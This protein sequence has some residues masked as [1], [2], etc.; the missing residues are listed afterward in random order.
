[1]RSFDWHLPTRIVFGRGRTAELETRLD[2]AHRRILVVTDKTIAGGTEILGKILKILGERETAVFDDVEENPTFENVESGSRFARVFN[3]DLVLG[4]GGG[5]AMDAA[6][7]IALKARNRGPLSRFLR[8]EPLEEDPLPGAGI[9]TTSGTGSEVTPYAVFTDFENQTKSAISHPK[10]FPEVAIIDPELTYSMPSAVVLNTGLDVLAHAAEAYLSTL[11]F[12]VNDT[13]ALH[14]LETA[15]TRLPGAVRKNTDDMDQMAFAATMAGI[16][17]TNAST[18]LPHVAGY[19]LTVFHGVPHGRASAIM[20]A[21]ALAFLRDSGSA[22]EKVAVLDRVFAHRGGLGGFLH[23]LG[24]AT[25][26]SEYGVREDEISG[27]VEKTMV[28]GDLK[29]TPAE[30]SAASLAEIYRSAL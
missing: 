8:G 5:S 29:I 16:A 6:K 26:L 14:A 18:I 25:R 21:A 28:K 3:P 23:D 27:Y 1:M 7:G 19:P 4:L 9:P 10:L 24:V 17:I 13:L 15:L 22:P 12:P 20:L 11:S 2:P 30:I